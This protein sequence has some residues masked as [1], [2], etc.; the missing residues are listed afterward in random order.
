MRNSYTALCDLDP[1][2]LSHLNIYYA[3]T[4]SSVHNGLHKGSAY[5]NLWA[6]AFAVPYLGTPHPNL[7]YVQGSPSHFLQV[8]TQC[9]THEITAVLGSP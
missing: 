7:T 8:S 6:F 3:V 2:Y 4:H 5:L 1:S 9:H